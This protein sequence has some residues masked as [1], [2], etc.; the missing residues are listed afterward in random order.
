MSS[1]AADRF[2]FPLC[3]RILQKLGRDIIWIGIHR[4]TVLPLEK[5]GADSGDSNVNQNFELMFLTISL[6]SHLGLL[7]HLRG[8]MNERPGSPL[9]SMPSFST[10]CL[11]DRINLS[12]VL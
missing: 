3:F 5:R 1:K 4:K 8:E 12:S 9:I 11:S 10:S 7:K 6:E 2:P